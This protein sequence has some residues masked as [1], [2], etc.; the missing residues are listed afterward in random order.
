[1]QLSQEGMVSS[2][3]R[4][5]VWIAHMSAWTAGLQVYTSL[6]VKRLMQIMKQISLS[7][8]LSTV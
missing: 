7:I 2:R 4:V 1:M 3:E 6:N 5:S 8:L